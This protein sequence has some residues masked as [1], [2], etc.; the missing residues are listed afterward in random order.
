MKTYE[1]MMS[2]YPV[3]VLLVLSHLCGV[4]GHSGTGCKGQSITTE[5]VSLMLLRLTVPVRVVSHCCRNRK[6]ALLPDPLNL[7]GN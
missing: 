7:G 1:V 4:E 3:G 5:P 6:V 2:Y